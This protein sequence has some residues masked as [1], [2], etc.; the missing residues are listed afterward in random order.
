M[1]GDVWARE[2]EW[3]R[4]YT[5]LDC[6]MLRRGIHK[7]PTMVSQISPLFHTSTVRPRSSRF[8]SLLGSKRKRRIK[9]KRNGLG[10]SRGKGSKI[11]QCWERRGCIQTPHCTERLQHKYSLCH[12]ELLSNLVMDMHRDSICRG[13]WVIRPEDGKSRWLSMIWR[14]RKPRLSIS[15]LYNKQKWT[16]SHF[17]P[18]NNIRIQ[19]I[20]LRSENDLYSDYKSDWQIISSLIISHCPTVPLLK[21]TGCL[22][23]IKS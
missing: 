16:L 10:K 11:I 6:R 23:W 3:E 8:I 21:P 2:R 12:Q 13:K 7:V 18:S 9:S 5:S 14:E 19:S 17:F 15:L 20:Q 1:L 22:N 4:E